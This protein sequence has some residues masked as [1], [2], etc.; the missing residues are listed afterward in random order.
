MKTD[1]KRLITLDKHNGI[2]LHTPNPESLWSFLHFPLLI[3]LPS[4][5]AC[6]N[7]HKSDSVVTESDL[8]I[9]LT[10]NPSIVVFK[11]DVLLCVMK[12]EMKLPKKV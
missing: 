3:Y 9:L 12:Y 5:M 6:S 11:N 7:W 8:L 1:D 10:Y 2:I 4:Q